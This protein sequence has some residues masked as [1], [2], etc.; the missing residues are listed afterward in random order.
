MHGDLMQVPFCA[1]AGNIAAKR[2]RVTVERG[3]PRIA[4]NPYVL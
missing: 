3:T 4:Q 2:K 1:L